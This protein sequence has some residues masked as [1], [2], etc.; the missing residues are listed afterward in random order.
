MSAFLPCDFLELAGRDNPGL[1]ALRWIIGVLSLYEWYRVESGR[2]VRRR[3][4][5]ELVLNT[6]HRKRDRLGCRL[7]S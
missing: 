5:G 3:C 4:E 7:I 1:R 2:A 6:T